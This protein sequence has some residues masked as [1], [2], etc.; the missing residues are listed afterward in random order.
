MAEIGTDF[1]SRARPRAPGVYLEEVTP[2]RAPAFRTGVPIFVGFVED[3][4]HDKEQDTDRRVD[5]YTLTRWEQFAEHVGRSV[6]GGFLEYAVRGFFENGGELCVVV[7]LRLSEDQR[8]SDAS[9]VL[10][11]LFAKDER[12]LRGLLEDIEDTDLVCV[13]DIMLA[14]I[15]ASHETVSELQQQVL[16]ETVFELQQQVLEYCKDMGDRFAILDALPMGDDKR[17][18]STPVGEKISDG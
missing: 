11:D 18:V 14:G 6:P 16:E 10:K 17:I 12:R 9:N 7:A 2:E 5:R 4:K 1:G 13:P 3:A 15:R 8:S